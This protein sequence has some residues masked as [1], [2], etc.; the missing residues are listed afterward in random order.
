MVSSLF[1]S[2][3]DVPVASATYS[4]LSG[5]VSRFEWMRSR[6]LET[7]GKRSPNGMTCDLNLK[8]QLWEAST[9]LTKLK[10]YMNKDFRTFPF[11]RIAR[12]VASK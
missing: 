6:M 10:K 9:N 1:K 12:S 4:T 5:V 2:T 8:L 3:N 11:F 7:N